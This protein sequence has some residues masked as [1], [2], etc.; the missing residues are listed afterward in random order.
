MSGNPVLSGLRPTHPGEFLREE[1][2]P[3][4]G[5]PRTEIAKRLGISRAMLY[6]IL[7]ERAPV[8]PAMAL[9]FARLLGTS[10]ESWLDMQRDYHL[11][12]LEAAMSEELARI[13][14]VAA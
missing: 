2:L 3:A 14:P 4:L 12:T 9:R 6:A 7:E 5:I 10:P 11:R 1:V 13:E 8:S